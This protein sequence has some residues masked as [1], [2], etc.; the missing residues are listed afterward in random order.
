MMRLRVLFQFCT[1]GTLIGGVYYRAYNGTLQ[2]PV[3][4]ITQDNRV[5]LHNGPF[6]NNGDGQQ[7][8]T[9]EKKVSQMR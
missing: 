1:I 3:G 2:S 6:A 8:Q 5:F 4:A 7:G 9:E